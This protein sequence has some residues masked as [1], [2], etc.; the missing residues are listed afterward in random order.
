MQEKTT[1]ET[2]V[3][4]TIS[5]RLRSRIIIIS[6]DVAVSGGGGGG[7]DDGG[8]G[9]GKIIYFVFL[10]ARLLFWNKTEYTPSTNAVLEK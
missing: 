6:I 8:G 1:Q 3:R 5:F 7:R 10:F 4:H 9:G 2:I